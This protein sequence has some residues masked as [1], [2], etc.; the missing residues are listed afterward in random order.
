MGA[1][2]GTCTAAGA[3]NINDT[4]NLPAGGSVDLHGQLHDLPGGDRHAEQHR[5]GRRA[6]GVTDPNPAN[7]SATDTDTAGAQADLAITKTDGVDDG[8]AGRLGDVHD[9]RLQRRPE[10]DDRRDRG[11]YLPGRPHLHVDLRGR[12]RGHLHGGWRRQHQ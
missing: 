6:G 4:V 5:D 9:R 1:G 3:G 8:D 11:G 10:R 12:G 7:N 2:G